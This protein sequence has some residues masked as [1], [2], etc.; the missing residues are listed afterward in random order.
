VKS[1]TYF[2]IANTSLPPSLLR[3]LQGA[4]D[5]DFVNR[6]ICWLNLSKVLCNSR[7]YMLMCIYK[8]EALLITCHMYHIHSPHIMDQYHRATQTPILHAVSHESHI[9]AA[10]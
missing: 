9:C 1:L 10:W 7:V 8:V 2:L 5:V 6:E 4:I 3:I